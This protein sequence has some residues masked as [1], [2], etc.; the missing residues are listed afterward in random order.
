MLPNVTKGKV[1]SLGFYR[2]RQALQVILTEEF[3]RK[4]IY[5]DEWTSP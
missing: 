4:I 2:W 5:G 3:P 1:F